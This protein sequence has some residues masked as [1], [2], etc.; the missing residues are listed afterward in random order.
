[1]MD[2]KMLINL[3]KEHPILYDSSHLY[4]MDIARKLQIWKD[5]GARMN[6]DGEKC[7][8]RWNN[9][10]DNYKKSL[11]K[12]LKAT[13]QQKCIKPYR[14]S[15]HLNFLRKHM[16][17]REPLL[18]LDQSLQL[19][20][21]K[22]V[23]D[24]DESKSQ[25][26]PEVLIKEE[27]TQEDNGSITPDSEPV[28]SVP[29]TQSGAVRKRKLVRESPSTVLMKY[30]LEKKSAKGTGIQGQPTVNLKHPIDAFLFSLS[31]SLKSLS[32]QLLTLAKSEIFAC[33]Q[34]YEMKLHSSKRN[35]AVANNMDMQAT[36]SEEEEQPLGPIIIGTSELRNS[37]GECPES[38]STTP[39]SSQTPIEP[40]PKKKQS[41]P[42]GSQS[43]FL[44]LACELLSSCSKQ[45]E[46][47][48]DEYLEVAKFWASKLKAL[49]PMQK[50]LAERA[51]NEILFEADLG[52]LH[53]NSLQIN[54]I[55]EQPSATTPHSS[56]LL[57][58]VSNP[59]KD[60]EPQVIKPIVRRSR[61]GVRMF[62]DTV[63]FGKTDLVESGL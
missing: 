34:K 40:P 1:M 59:L 45:P 22:M 47:T 30:L 26:P 29:T 15:W 38:V 44:K 28:L 55:R 9:I 52:T 12:L 54:Y 5:I 10:R 24:D 33:V 11:K 58:V 39:S 7:K 20:E 46:E 8:A 42:A 16:N 18:K 27:T 36:S 17:D 35:S 14:F 6:A 13:Q 43:E 2:D 41:D 48:S 4:Y 50:K 62:S 63:S 56:E 3:V 32:P 53:R 21:D 31:P 60:T 23:D 37:I 57:P 49:V 61:I 19:S 51:I 25:L